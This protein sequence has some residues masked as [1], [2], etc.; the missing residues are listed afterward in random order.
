MGHCLFMR[1][2]SVHKK[3]SLLPSGYTEL[4]YIQSSGTQYIDAGLK[5]D[6]D[7][8]LLMDAQLTSTSNYPSLFGTRNRD[9]QMFWL[10]A[11]SATQIIFGFGDSKPSATCTMSDRLAIDANKNTLTVN[12]SVLATATASTFTAAG[13]LYLCAANNNGTLQ[14]AAQMKLYSC[15]IYDNGTLVRDFQ[16]CIDAS[17]AVGLYDLVGRQ[18]YGN[19]GT[20]SF[21]GSEVE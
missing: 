8:R 13:N 19:A 2:G 6:Q 3:P 1:K 9:K 4:A 12:G 10:F 5:P 14:Y 18:F 15:Q 21:T 16:P 11:N 17:G 7:T 20:G